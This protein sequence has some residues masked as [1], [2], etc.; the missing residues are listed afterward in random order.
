M[1]SG[2]GQRVGER[3]VLLDTAAGERQLAQVSSRGTIVPGGV[4]VDGAGQVLYAYTLQ[5]QRGKDTVRYSRLGVGA[6]EQ[7]LPYEPE[8]G[9]LEEL[10]GGGRAAAPVTFVAYQGRRLMFYRSGRELRMTPLDALGYV[11]VVATRSAY[12]L[13]PIVGGD[14]VLYVFYYEPKSRAAR[15][16]FTKDGHSF[17]DLVLDTRESGW[18]LDAVATEDG[19]IVTYYYFRNPY[20]KGLRAAFVKQGQLQRP[21]QSVVLEDRWNAG[22]HPYLVRDASGATYFT[23]LSNV[24]AGLRAWSLFKR[25]QELLDHETKTT[26]PDYKNWFV[27]AGAGGWY[28]WWNL[29]STA[30][31]AKE[32]DGAS[33]HDASYTVEPSLLLSANL[34]ARIGPLSLGLMYA[35]NYLDEQAKNLGEIN[36]L[37]S[38]NLQIE[39]LLPGHD[40]KVEGVWGRYHGRATREVEGLAPEQQELDTSYLDVRLFALNQWRIKYG[41]TFNRFEVPTPLFAYYAG[42]NETHYNYAGS[43]L[44]NVAYNN[45]DLAVGYSK[46]DYLAKYENDY[47]GPI[48]DGGLAL[49][50]SIVGFDAV[51]TPVGDTSSDFGFNLRCN[52]QAGWL[53]M[54]RFRALAGFGLYLRPS[55]SVEA[56]GFTNFVVRPEDRKAD[57]AKQAS[58]SAKFELW[59][60]RHGPW[61]DAGIVW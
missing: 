36:R 22:W 41:L 29:A 57:D 31:E 17:S 9:A 32:V 11:S 12:D 27:Q 19:V 44:R 60:L 5:E 55:Y 16:A 7:Q 18:Q 13:E 46:L 48:L 53:A 50:V 37:L 24:E 6:G 2:N 20:N 42:E 8:A 30:P 51:Q 14:G 61:L 4:F 21:P 33:V 47:F 54:T 3:L 28:T 15:V 56:A 1:F 23:Y 38:G 45:I 58:E 52:L 40:V 43:V 25:P 39:D 34:E 49:G 35:Q 59:S 10:G 26:E